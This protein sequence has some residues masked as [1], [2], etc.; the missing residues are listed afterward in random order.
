MADE[1][2]YADEQYCSE[3]DYYED[4]DGYHYEYDYDDYGGPESE[5]YRDLR[6]WLKNALQPHMENTTVG[7]KIGIL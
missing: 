6:I 3:E 2:F 1:E 7:N 4:D 5:I